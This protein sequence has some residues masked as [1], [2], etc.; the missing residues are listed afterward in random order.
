VEQYDLMRKYNN[1]TTDEERY[2]FVNTHANKGYLKYLVN[3]VPFS[4]FMKMKELNMLSDKCNFTKEYLHTLVNNSNEFID[5]TNQVINNYNFSFERLQQITNEMFCCESINMTNCHYLWPFVVCNTTLFEAEKTKLFEPNSAIQQYIRKRFNGLYLFQKDYNKN[6]NSS[7][8]MFVGKIPTEIMYIENERIY[9]APYIIQFG[10]IP[11]YVLNGGHKFKHCY[12]C[13]KLNT[14]THFEN[15]SRMCYQCGGFN[16]HMRNLK[17]NLSNVRAYVSGCRHTVGYFTCLQLL[18]MGAFVVGSSRFVDVAL[19]N[20]QQ[21]P[22]YEEFKDRLVLIA[23]DFLNTSQVNHMLEFLKTQNL[24][25]YINNAFQTIRQSPTY[26]E[27]IETLQTHINHLMIENESYNKPTKDMKEEN[28]VMTRMSNYQMTPYKPV[29]NT[30]IDCSQSKIIPKFD[31]EMLETNGIVI[32]E[33]RNLVEV[34]Y[35]TSWTQTLT[36]MDPQEI[37]E[38]TIINQIV[39][40]LI[41]KSMVTMMKPTKENVCFIINV[42]STEG[43]HQTAIHNVTGS[44][45]VAMDNLIR[46]MYYEH[47]NYMHFFNVDPGFV[48]GVF[49]GSSKPLSSLDGAQRVLHPIIEFYRSNPLD[50]KGYWLKDYNAK[51]WLP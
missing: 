43:N 20:Y 13:K 6:V 7:R 26:Y 47:R 41:I 39:P 12:V 35:E 22:D 8:A 10:A 45:K 18:R 34:D 44:Q 9:V 38:G 31:Q 3:F 14:L 24:N 4:V 36:E 5:V 16:F 46:N 19:Y 2:L 23:C 40:T 50:P 37:I 32:N 42:T 33:H 30:I 49:H 21:E 51:Y 27:R 48:T 15:Y 29:E 1:K 28:T 11:E 25:V 17:T